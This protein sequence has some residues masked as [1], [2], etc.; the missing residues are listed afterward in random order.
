MIQFHDTNVNLPKARQFTI[1]YKIIILIFLEL[2]DNNITK[3]N[4]PHYTKAVYNW[5]VC[6]IIYKRKKKKILYDT[7]YLK[8]YN[9]ID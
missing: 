9:E 4:T 8:A 6:I 2:H 7:N 1:C 3:S 5:Q